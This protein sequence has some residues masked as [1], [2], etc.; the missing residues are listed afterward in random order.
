MFDRRPTFLSHAFDAGGAY[1][2]VLHTGSDEAGEP[3]PFL[4]QISVFCTRLRCACGSASWS[5]EAMETY[6]FDRKHPFSLS[7]HFI[8]L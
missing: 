1:T 2:V 5:D 7:R 4:P 6:I 8:C 3:L